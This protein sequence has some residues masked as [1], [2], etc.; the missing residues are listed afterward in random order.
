MNRPLNFVLVCGGLAAAAAFSAVR[1][2]D[3]EGQ[4]AK[5]QPGAGDVLKLEAKKEKPAPIPNFAKAY[6]VPFESFQTVGSRLADAR[7][8]SDPIAL[9]LIAC[10]LESLGEKVFLERSG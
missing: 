8:K 3:G 1:H 2:A 10:E 9:A 4:D 5:K 7:Q 6:G